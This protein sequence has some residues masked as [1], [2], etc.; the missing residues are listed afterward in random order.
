MNHNSVSFP[1]ADFWQKALYSFFAVILFT[2]AVLSEDKMLPPEFARIFSQKKLVVAMLAVDQPPYFMKDSHGKLIGLDVE[3]ATEIANVLGVELELK[4]T[5]STFDEVVQQV[6][7][8]EA[9]IAVSDLSR[10]RKRGLNVLFSRPYLRLKQAL[11]L[12]R[13][14]SKNEESTD[15]LNSSNKKIGVLEGSSY[16][17]FAKM[18]FPEASVQTYN[19]W[20][21]AAFAV[22]NGRIDAALMDDNEVITWTKLHPEALLYAQ[23]RVLPDKEDNISVITHWQ[24]HHLHEWINLHIDLL[25]SEGRLEQ[26]KKKYFVHK[27][28]K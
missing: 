24:D 21:S 14:K 16:V 17:D 4:R 27:K 5:A 12:N 20:D 9:D 8:K 26:L 6:A 7:R 3:L 22:I 10:T 19:L 28:N 25:E 11:L 2:N 15:W 18:A 1:A 13:L 23:V